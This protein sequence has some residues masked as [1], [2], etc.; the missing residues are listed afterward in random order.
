MISIEFYSLLAQKFSLHPQSLYSFDFD[1]EDLP[2][3]SFSDCLA[4]L[5]LRRFGEGNFQVVFK[6]GLYLK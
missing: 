5:K 3:S 1:T 4:K 2:L 6:M